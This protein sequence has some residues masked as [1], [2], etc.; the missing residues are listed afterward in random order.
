M[1][2]LLSNHLT[3]LSKIYKGDI[4]RTVNS[5]I[6]EWFP[7]TIKPFLEGPLTP[8]AEF[9]TNN[10]KEFIGNNSRWSLELF[11]FFVD[12]YL[13]A[14]PRERLHRLVID[15]GACLGGF[16][17][18]PHGC[19]DPAVKILAFEPNPH[20]MSI[21]EKRLSKTDF[22][23]G[24]WINSSKPGQTDSRVRIPSSQVHLFP[25]A[26]SDKKSSLWLKVPAP[27]EWAGARGAALVEEGHE[28]HNSTSSSKQIKVEVDR[29]DNILSTYGRPEDLNINFIK[30]DAEGQDIKVIKGLGDYLQSVQFLEFEANHLLYPNIKGEGITLDDSVKDI[31]AYLDSQGFNVYHFGQK[32]V[33]QLN[34]DKWSEV[35][36]ALPMLFN[37]N[38]FCVQKNIPFWSEI[39][40]AEGE[41]LLLDEL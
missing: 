15:V 8:E 41:Y 40:N 6:P 29:L 23:A 7:S 30:I 5:R 37:L 34:G 12:H 33:L 14:N 35:Y 24:A 28:H 32:R 20:S 3:E 11:R 27:Y 36:K 1:K 31:I 17:F 13:S 18:L 2:N 39:A 4:E 16:T 25:Q 26:L 21:I 10:L 19:T 22:I 9:F 38:L